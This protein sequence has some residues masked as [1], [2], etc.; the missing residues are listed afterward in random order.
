MVS[1]L[2]TD[3][4]QTLLN[5]D[6]TISPENLEA[7]NGFIDRGNYFAFV[8]GRPFVDSVPFAEKYGLDRNGV[9]I[10]GFNGGEIWGYRDTS[11]QLISSS[12]LSFEDA[13]FLFTEAE[14][15]NIHCQ[16]YYDKYVIALH[17]TDILKSYTG[18]RHLVPKAIEG[19]DNLLSYLPS[20]PP[21]VVCVR[22][23]D[24]EG[25][26]RFKDHVD[27]HI[28]GRLFSLFSSDRLLEFGA[29]NATKG[30]AIKALAERMN[31][32]M[33]NTYA[34]GDEENDISMIET[35]GTG[36]AV[37]NARKEVK[38]IADRV[39]LNDNDHGAIAEI[40][41]EIERI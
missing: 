28:K 33:E 40:I 11:F 3:L 2:F 16:T 12:P 4:D 20:P 41:R 35:A 37:K 25:L 29:L 38:D 1:F 34:A 26:Q 23:N 17:D 32:P 8:T 31:V 36:F 15:F 39:T 22:D 13:A 21:K 7:I 18:G 30:A 27:P 19:L 24:R 5:T 9:F 10:A 6:K 14:K